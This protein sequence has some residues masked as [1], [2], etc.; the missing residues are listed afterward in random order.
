MKT[1]MVR[2]EAAASAG[3]RHSISMLVLP[4]LFA[5]TAAGTSNGD[6]PGKQRERAPAL[7]YTIAY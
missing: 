7:A 1:W 3:S 6:G 4:Y 5:Q 2:C